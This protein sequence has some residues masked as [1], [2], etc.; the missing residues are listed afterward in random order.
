M[1]APAFEN[2]FLATLLWFATVW[3]QKWVD[4][5]AEC[6]GVILGGGKTVELV[7]IGWNGSGHVSDWGK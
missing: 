2:G 4:R 3:W 6:G 1:I 7:E 5:P